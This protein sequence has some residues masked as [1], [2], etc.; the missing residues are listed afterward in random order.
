MLR[1]LVIDDIPNYRILII[2]ELKRAF[3]QVQTQ[4]IVDEAEFGRALEL[5]EFDLVVTD[6]Q[7]GW[8]D[9]ITILRQVKECYPNCPVIIPGSH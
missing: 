7:L 5:G 3:K 6:Y 8:S 4:E 9:G 1:I 2:R